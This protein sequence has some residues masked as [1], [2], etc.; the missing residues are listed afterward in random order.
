MINENTYEA[1]IGIEVH[2][3]LKTK[4]KIFCSCPNQFGDLPNKNICP[5]CAG[6]P[7]TLPVLNKK[8][9]DFAIAL[10]IATNSQ[11]SKACDFARKHYMYPDLPKNFQITQDSKP[12]CTEGFI[13]IDL[14]DNSEKKIRLVRIHIEEDAGKNI[15]ANTGE[16]L[17]DLNRAGTPLLEIVSY[18]D[19][20]SSDEAK[21]YLMR[22]RT[23]AQYVGISDANMEEGS[24]RADVNVS[25]KKRGAQALGTRVELKNINSFKFITQ[26]INFEIERQIDLLESNN[27]V[28]TETRAW[29][30]KE[31]KTIFMR[32]KEEAEDYRYFVEP[33]LPILMINDEWQKRIQNDLPELPHKKYH[34]F[35]KEYSLTKDEAESLTSGKDIA[36]F[37]EKTSSL[38]KKPKS[39]SNWM[40]RDVFAYLK[41]YKLSITECKITPE[42][43]SELIMEIDRGIITGKTAQDV[44]LEMASTGKY[45]SILIQDNGLTQ[46]GSSSELEPIILQI[47]QD[48]PEQVEKYRSGN[49]RLFTFFVGQAMKKTNGKGNPQIIKELLE[50]FLKNS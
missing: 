37:F 8:V 13:P 14:P 34:R 49:E 12:I 47:I 35:Q 41:E 3:Q 21:A 16:S 11:I 43:L 28:H 22:L 45:P 2:L 26:A 36:D 42:T 46:I 1:N 6:Y 19:M 44:F 20:T 50:R 30:E 9:V 29:D 27:S 38:C 33:D 39:V 4:S 10:G 7:G 18:P 31:H 15:H 25:V 17:V 32:S 48:N 24:F 40:L 23:I 5:I